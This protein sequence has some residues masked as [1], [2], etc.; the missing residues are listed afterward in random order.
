MD[1]TTSPSSSSNG[2]ALVQ[3]IVVVHNEIRFDYMCACCR[4]FGMDKEA[5]A[6]GTNTCTYKYLFKELTSSVLYTSD[7]GLV[8]NSIKIKDKMDS[9]KLPRPPELNIISDGKSKEGNI[10]YCFGR[11]RTQGNIC[12]CFGRPRPPDQLDSNEHGIVG[13]KRI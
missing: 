2:V 4:M 12:Y 5:H 8:W 11:P 10:C 13:I 3:E 1:D 7:S 6:Y 9:F